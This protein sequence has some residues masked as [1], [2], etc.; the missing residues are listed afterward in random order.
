MQN[1]ENEQFLFSS[2]YSTPSSLCIQ[3]GPYNLQGQLEGQRPFKFRHLKKPLG[4]FQLRTSDYLP[5]LLQQ[6]VL[7]ASLC[8]SKEVM[9]HDKENSEPTAAEPICVTFEDVSAAPYRI[10]DGVPQTPCEV[11]IIM[12]LATGVMFWSWYGQTLSMY[13]Y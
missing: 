5:V 2:L 8:G 3:Q 11:R 13:E 4:I 6:W 9:D 12:E 7:S 10:R 1:K